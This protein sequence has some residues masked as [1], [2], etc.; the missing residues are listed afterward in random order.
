[1]FSNGQEL[2]LPGSH[3]SGIFY[4]CDGVEPEV[5]KFIGAQRELWDFI[6]T[7]LF[8][9]HFFILRSQKI[10]STEILGFYLLHFTLLPKVVWS[11]LIFLVEVFCSENQALVCWKGRWPATPLSK[12]HTLGIYSWL[13]PALCLQAAEV[14]RLHRRQEWGHYHHETSGSCGAA[15]GAHILFVT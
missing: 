12:C 7:H 6:T 2:E 5:G 11:H 4:L 13:L 1:M 8:S 10:G 14:P 3:H 9:R 15:R